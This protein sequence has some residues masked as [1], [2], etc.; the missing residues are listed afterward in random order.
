M[1]AWPGG[2]AMPLIPF[3]SW[4]S[5]QLWRDKRGRLSALRIATLALLLFPLAKALF[6]ARRDRC[7]ARGR[8]TTSSTAPVSGR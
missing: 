2:A 6:D 3:S 1:Q 4:D 5:W 8:S 7:T